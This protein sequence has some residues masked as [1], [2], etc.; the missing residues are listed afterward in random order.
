MLHKSSHCVCSGVFQLPVARE[1]KHSQLEEDEEVDDVHE[2]C[3]F[4]TCCP[5]Q[6]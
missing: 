4:R 5:G 2:A 1:E 6:P 3:R